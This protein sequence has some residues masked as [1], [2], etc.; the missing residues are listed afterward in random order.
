MSLAALPANPRPI[1]R[2]RSVLRL[3]LEHPYFAPAPPQGL[4]L[5]AD[6]PTARALARYELRLRALDDGAELIAPDGALAALAADA[7]AL[8]GATLTLELRSTDPSCA[9]Y[10]DLRA[11]AQAGVYRPDPQQST[12]L[13]ATPESTPA[14]AS[15]A[16]I[17][18]PLAALHD[19]DERAPATC[20][21]SL[22]VRQTYWKYLLLDENCLDENFLGADAPDS[23]QL[24]DV[25]GRVEFGDGRAHTVGAGRSAVAFTA[26]QPLALQQR[27]QRRFQL[28]RRQGASERVVIARMPM[29]SPASLQREL[30]DGAMADISEIYVSL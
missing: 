4:V 20:T 16:R 19:S 18:L 3:R 30:V 14:G 27:P 29:P 2:Y 6:P 22:P 25:D 21:L 26:R 12:R 24:V 15:L 8:P 28:C 5:Q 9:Y 1:T 7:D 23:L 17:A 10:T 11:L 13:I